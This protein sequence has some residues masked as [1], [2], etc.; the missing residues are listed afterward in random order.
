MIFQG[1]I[2]LPI[3]VQNM[4]EQIVDTVFFLVFFYNGDST[5]YNCEFEI[6]ARH[7][8]QSF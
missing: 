5:T 2:V 3:N 8:S 1:I 6:C 4:K 7:K